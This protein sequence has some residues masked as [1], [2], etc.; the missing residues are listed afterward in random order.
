TAAQTDN[1]FK[2][3]YTRI[4]AARIRRFDTRNLNVYDAVLPITER[5]AKT[6]REM[7]CRLPVEVVPA[8]ID[9]KRMPLQITQTTGMDLFFIGALDWGPNQ[10][11]LCWFLDKCWPQIQKNQSSLVFHIAGR[12]APV[13]L[14]KRLAQKG[15][16]YHGEVENAYEYMA[17]HRIMVVPLLSGG[18]MRIKIIEGMAMGK[19]IV[20]TPVGAEGIDVQ[21]SS[22]IMLGNS[23]EIMVDKILQLVSDEQLLNNISSRA[24][25]DVR[26]KFNNLRIS[27]SLQEFYK[28]LIS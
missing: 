18:G 12:N 23:A 20:S 1:F 9:F 21:D 6:F 16:F 8:G 15:I 13:W 5:D 22:N 28:T 3:W 7:G 25:A 19:A 14:V 11:G 26:E 4:L 17:A 27:G 2:R 10:E 24:Y